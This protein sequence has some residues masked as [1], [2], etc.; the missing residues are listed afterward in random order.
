VVTPHPFYGVVLGK[1]F[2]P[3]RQGTLLVTFRD[4]SN[5]CAE[6]LAFEVVDFSWPY[7]VILRRSCYVKFMA[8]TSYAY[9]NLKIPGP[10]GLSLWRPKRS[11]R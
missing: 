3:L 10:I 11:E 6:T 4:A 2:I 7:H 9:L 1:Q 8:I 5:S